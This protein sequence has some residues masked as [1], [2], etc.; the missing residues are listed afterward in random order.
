MMT[1][2]TDYFEIGLRTAGAVSAGAY[3]AGV[4]DFLLQAFGDWGPPGTLR[5]ISRRATRR[6]CGGGIPGFAG[7]LGWRLPRGRVIDAVMGRTFR[8]LN[9]AGPL[10]K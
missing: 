6:P 7:R 10:R 5:P 8:G 2:A 1:D 4:V 9:E 3:T